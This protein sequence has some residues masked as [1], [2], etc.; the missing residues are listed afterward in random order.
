MP[1]LQ[2]EGLNMSFGGVRAVKDLSFAVERGSIHSIIGPNGAG[3]T[4][5]FNLL[6]GLYRPTSG[7]VLLDGR[8]L[9]G[10]TPCQLARQ[11]MARTFQNLQIFF[12][13]TAVENVMVGAHLRLDGRILHSMLRLP[14]LVRR[15]AECREEAVELM[16]FVGIGRYAFHRANALPYGALKRLEIARALAARPR[17]LLLDEPAAGL[18]PTETEEM[19]ALIQKIARRGVTVMLVEHDMKLVMGISH[20]ILVLDRGSKLFEGTAPEVSGNPDVISA[21]LGTAA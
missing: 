15:D 21:Y 7:R 8:D 13:M 10:K 14:S 20:R 2:V 3:K 17:L 11:G 18:N 19:N 5:V 4:T 9:T 6:I 12:N 1:L 16:S